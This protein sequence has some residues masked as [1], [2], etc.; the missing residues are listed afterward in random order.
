M[1]Q[2]FLFFSALIPILIL[3]CNGR[4]ESGTAA[5]PGGKTSGEVG[6]GN[7]LSMKINGVE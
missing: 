1:S 7:Y 3:V 4:P 2:K 5:A 6:T